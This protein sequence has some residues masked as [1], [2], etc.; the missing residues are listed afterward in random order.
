MVGHR[1]SNRIQRRTGALHGVELAVE[2]GVVQAQHVG[3]V[4]EPTDGLAHRAAAADAA[5]TE[6]D[7]PLR[8][9]GVDG[10]DRLTVRHESMH[11]DAA[12]EHHHDKMIAISPN[13]PIPIF[14]AMR[15]AR[16]EVGCDM[17]TSTWH[18]DRSC[19]RPTVP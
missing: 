15:R 5:G 6:A 14:G 11:A 7:G 19:A 16:R 8:V 18:H 4:G 1:K 10:R 12:A 2:R 9:V 13:A 17:S 3:G